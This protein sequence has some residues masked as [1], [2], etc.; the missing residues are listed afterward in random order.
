MHNTSS[1]GVETQKDTEALKELR[2]AL[3]SADHHILP[4]NCALGARFRAEGGGEGAVEVDPGLDLQD[5][6]LY[7]DS[8]L[9]DTQAI[10]TE[11]S[12]GDSV[13]MLEGAWK[14]DLWPKLLMGS[15]VICST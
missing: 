1:S 15:M 8:S 3:V 2:R 14:T 7:L 4:R 11:P 10:F 6:L 9:N 12:V 5:S 13:S